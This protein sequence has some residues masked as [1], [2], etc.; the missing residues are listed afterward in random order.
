MESGDGPLA[1]CIVL[2]V[3]IIFNSILYGFGSAIQHLNESEIEKKAEEGDKKSRILM[4]MLVRPEDLVSTI[5]FVATLMS[6][7]IGIFLIRD[8]TFLLTN[9]LENTWLAFG[10]LI[11]VGI[12]TM[13]LLISLGISAP[14]K[15]CAHDADKKAY[16]LLPFVRFF[17]FLFLPLSKAASVISNLVVRCFGIDPHRLT[18]DVTEDEIIDLVDEAH[19]QGVIQE[20]EAE[21]IQNIMEFSDKD[22]K[23]IMTHRKNI[24]ALDDTMTLEEAVSFMAENSNSRYPV[25]HESIDNITG[26]IHIKDAMVQFT[27]QEYQKSTLVQIPQL[28]RSIAYIPETRS[29]DAIFQAMQT[30]KMHMVIVVDEYGQTA[31]LLTMEDILEEIVG[32]ILDEYDVSEDFIQP[33]ID[34]SILMDGLTPLDDVEKV[35]EIDLGEHEF[36]TLNGYLTSLLGHIPTEEDKEINA[37]GYCFQILSVENNIIQKIRVEKIQ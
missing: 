2:F 15:I 36:E 27:S 9:H 1:G 29:I 26:F 11:L 23:D 35:L 16:Q 6:I 7:L 30:K 32:N 28:I 33:Q 20:S 22:A 31:G 34:E 5:Q 21:M 14:K 3:F 4:K 8:V 37:N 18:D 12:V 17:I 24:K 19:E 13:I 25:Y 10:L